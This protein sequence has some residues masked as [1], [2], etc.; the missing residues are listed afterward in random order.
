MNSPDIRWNVLRKCLVRKLCSRAVYSSTMYARKPHL[1]LVCKT[2]STNEC[3]KK[4]RV[5]VQRPILFNQLLEFSVNLHNYS[6][7]CEFLT[8]RVECVTSAKSRYEVC[9]YKWKILTRTRVSY[10]TCK[11]FGLRTDDK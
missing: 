4:F 6:F 3:L 8:L 1:A 2:N 10:L 7:V 9:F 11:V 5:V